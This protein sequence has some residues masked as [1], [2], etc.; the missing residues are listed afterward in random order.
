V[1]QKRSRNGCVTPQ[2]HLRNTRGAI[3]TFIYMRSAIVVS[4]MTSEQGGSRLMCA[5]VRLVAFCDR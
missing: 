5:R 2:I 1:Q 4:F 3:H